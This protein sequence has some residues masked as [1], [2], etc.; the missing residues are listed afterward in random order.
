MENLIIQNLLEQ[1]EKLKEENRKLIEEN[2]R[3]KNGQNEMP[4]IKEN[5]TKEIIITKE[6]PENKYLTIEDMVNEKYQN[7]MSINE[8]ETYLKSKITEADLFEC[9]YKEVQVVVIDIL[10]RELSNKELRPI[11]KNKYYVV[12]IGDTWVKKEHYDFEKIIK[13]L[14]NIAVHTMNVI[15]INLRKTELY[16]NGGSSVH[17]YKHYSFDREEFTIKLMDDLNN[18][19]VSKTIGN[20]IHINL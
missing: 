2:T 6:I 16:I 17:K 19:V 14:I 7:S 13:R 1:V 4:I 10:T 8:F 9:L 18:Q 3:L 11:H 15:F 12:K 20:R 5:I